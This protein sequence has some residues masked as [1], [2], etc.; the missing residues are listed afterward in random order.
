MILYVR[1]GLTRRRR[2]SQKCSRGCLPFQEPLKS[3][4]TEC[5]AET[6]RVRPILRAQS[7][8]VKQHGAHC[9][10]FIA[11]AGLRERAQMTACDEIA[12]SQRIVTPA[13]TIIVESRPFGVKR[14]GGLA[15]N[16]Y[17][18][19]N[20]ARGQ[21]GIGALC[22]CYCILSDIHCAYSLCKCSNNSRHPQYN[23]GKTIFGIFVFFFCDGVVCKRIV[24]L[25]N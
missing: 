16:T 11:G 10:C 17:R 21:G 14:C 15:G 18:F 5:R 7:A 12:G 1:N 9:E 13:V 8:A 4:S 19:L 23:A 20:V 24:T 22:R 3:G 2:L 6:V 25:K